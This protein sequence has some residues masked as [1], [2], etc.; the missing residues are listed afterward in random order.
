MYNNL[1][2]LTRKALALKEGFLNTQ[3][4]RAAERFGDVSSTPEIRTALES[5]IQRK[6]SSAKKAGQTPH[7]H[8]KRIKMNY[9]ATYSPDMIH[10][11][12]SCLISQNTLGHIR[13]NKRRCGRHLHVAFPKAFASGRQ[14]SIEE[15]T[16]AKVPIF[17]AYLED[18]LRVGTL[19]PII[20]RE[21]MNDTSILGHS[22]PE[23][24][25]CFMSMQ[26]ATYTEPGFPISE[27][28]RSESSQ[29]HREVI[30]D[31][32]DT[33][34]SPN[35]F[36]PERWLRKDEN[37]EVVF[38][39]Y[40]RPFLPF[41]NG[42]RGCFG[43]RLAYLELRIVTILLVWNFEYLP[44]PSHLDSWDAHDSVVVK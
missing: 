11:I 44:L 34:F 36:L 25:M 42:P 31:W 29:K 19:L 41:S 39:Y 2:S 5:M 22:I 6:I 14:P 16:K 12:Q 43:K 9:T 40:A 3:I 23:G 28:S 21:A 33:P 15:V 13:M 26:G 35:E 24:T 7:L 8:S 4:T 1:F 18:V 38:D 32:A 17:N 27:M 37:G 30:G 10:L 20:G